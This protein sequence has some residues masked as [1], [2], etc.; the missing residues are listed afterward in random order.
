MFCSN[1]K[2]SSLVKIVYAQVITNNRLELVP[3]KLYAD[4]SLERNQ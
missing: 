3:L 4:G 1:Q 2:H